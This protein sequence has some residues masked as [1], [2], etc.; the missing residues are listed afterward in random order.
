LILQLVTDRR[1]L[2]RGCDERAA[3]RCVLEQAKHAVDAGVDLIRVREGD[4]EAR[5]LADLVARIVEIARGT[6]TQVVVTERLDVALS[7]GAAGVHLRADS[8]SPAAVRTIAPPGFLVGRSVHSAEEAV[9]AAEAAANRPAVD[10][11]VAGTV[12]TTS[13]KPPGTRLL[14]PQGLAHLA[15]AVRVPVLGIGGITLNRIPEV[16]RAGAAGFAAIGLF[17]ERSEGPDGCRAAPM[18]AVVAAARAAFGL[19]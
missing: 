14:G 11:L 15:A 17:M 1:Q 9:E 6:R 8:M 13:S 4:L 2:C 18:G 16:A 10:Y 12:W 5:P 19:T 3:A 7:C